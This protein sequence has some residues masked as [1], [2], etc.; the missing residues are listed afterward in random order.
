MDSDVEDAFQYRSI[1]I[2]YDIQMLESYRKIQNPQICSK[3]LSEVFGNQAKDSPLRTFI[4]TFNSSTR[5]S[6]TRPR[7]GLH[8]S[9]CPLTSIS[10]SLTT[11]S[12]IATTSNEAGSFASTTLVHRIIIN[13]FIHQIVISIR[14][15]HFTHQLI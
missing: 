1:S 7:D 13:F 15:H 2:R 10:S 4:S 12:N 11:T 6:D 8:C 14:Q 9:N 5:H 3:Y